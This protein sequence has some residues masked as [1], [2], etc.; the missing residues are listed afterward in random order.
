MSLKKL[1]FLDLIDWDFLIKCISIRESLIFQFDQLL[2]VEMAKYLGVFLTK[3]NFLWKQIECKNQIKWNAG[4]ALCQQFGI[5]KS[6]LCRH[7]N[8]C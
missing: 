2:N 1:V 5:P 4:S 8:F 3:P 7:E 6:K